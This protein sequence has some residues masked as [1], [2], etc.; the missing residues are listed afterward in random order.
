MTKEEWKTE[1]I[2]RFG[3]DIMNWKFV[4]PICG[5]VASVADYKN[6][7]AP[8]SAIAFNCI[9]RY[10][11]NCRSA[12]G[13]NSKNAPLKPCDYTGGGLF[14]LNPLEVEGGQYFNFAE[15]N[16]ELLKEKT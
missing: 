9:G 12:F 4:C 15:A 7:H 8:E 3:T 2:K 1:A 14:G 11:P 13:R 16:P 6:A 5:N 10:L